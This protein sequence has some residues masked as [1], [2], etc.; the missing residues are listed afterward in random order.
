MISQSVTMSYTYPSVSLL[1]ILFN[2]HNYKHV[3]T[4]DVTCFMEIHYIFKMH[5]IRQLHWDYEFVKSSVHYDIFHEL[6]LIAVTR[7]PS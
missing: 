2:C 3:Q 1:V 6:V 5:D 4:T 7:N